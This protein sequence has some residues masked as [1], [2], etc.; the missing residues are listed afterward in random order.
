MGFLLEKE[1]KSSPE[2][3]FAV[4]FN[5]TKVKIGSNKSSGISRA[6]CFLWRSSP[7]I[8]PPVLVLERARGLGLQTEQNLPALAP[9]LKSQ[10]IKA[11]PKI[12]FAT[13]II[14]TS[15]S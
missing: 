7:R 11:A 4:L 10:K 8:L 1:K 5:K 15:L 3:F 13:R 14:K 2:S 9:R 12:V 6:W